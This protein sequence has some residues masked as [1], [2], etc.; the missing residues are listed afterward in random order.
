[1]LRALLIALAAA[2]TH[3]FCAPS[4]DHTHVTGGSPTYLCL[5]LEAYDHS[6]ATLDY[7]PQL[8]DARWRTFQAFQATADDFSRFVIKGCE[9][10]TRSRPPFFWNFALRPQRL[11]PPRPIFFLYR[12]LVK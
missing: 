1:M 3:S 10:R 7:P 9:L 11:T 4:K 6:N 2:L 5:K 12:I 8:N